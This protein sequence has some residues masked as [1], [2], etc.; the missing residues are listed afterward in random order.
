MIVLD[1]SAVVE[2]VLRT[3]KGVRI[4]RWIKRFGGPL[5]VPHLLELEVANALRRYVRRHATTSARAE[6]AFQDMSAIRMTR[7]G[8]TLFLHRVW[9]LRHHLTAYDAVYVALAEALNAPLL[10]CDA[11]IAAGPGHRAIVEVV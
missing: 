3:E 9:E 8:H 11:K 5:H 1:A 4:G 7:H 6:E 10:T 2:W